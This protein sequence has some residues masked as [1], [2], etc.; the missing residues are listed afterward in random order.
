[1]LLTKLLCYLQKVPLKVRKVCNA[2]EATC[3]ANR[4]ALVMATYRDLL[5]LDSNQNAHGETV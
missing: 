1:M 4:W 2:A 3:P 5:F